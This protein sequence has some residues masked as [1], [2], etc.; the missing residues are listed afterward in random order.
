MEADGHHPAN[1]DRQQPPNEH[2]LEIR[3][4]VESRVNSICSI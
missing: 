2:D 1:Q 3:D 4:T